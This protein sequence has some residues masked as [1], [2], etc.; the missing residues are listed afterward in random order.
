[1]PPDVN[2]LTAEQL[3]AADKSADNNYVGTPVVPPKPGEEDNYLALPFVEEDAE[4][5]FLFYKHK[6]V[7]R[8]EIPRENALKDP[9]KFVNGIAKIRR[10]DEQEF[11]AACAGLHR[12]DSGNIVQI[13]NI[14]NEVALRPPEP[15]AFRGPAS[16]TTIKAPTQA[17]PA[18]SESA[19]ASQRPS[20]APVASPGLKSLLQ[21]NR[22]A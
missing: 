21:A 17:Q 1:M 7:S 12:A 4:V 14:Q 2:E 13:R 20:G 5:N 9:F 8:F 18:G 15:T 10:E 3:A 6:Q 22:I 19:V 16:T 11:L